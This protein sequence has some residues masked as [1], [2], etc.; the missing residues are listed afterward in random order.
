M[1]LQDLQPLVQAFLDLYIL[2]AGPST[3]VVF[4]GAIAP[5]IRHRSPAR[6]GIPPEYEPILNE[7]DQSEFE[8][9]AG[10]EVSDVS[11]LFLD[12][13]SL[14]RAVV[15]ESAGGLHFR[16]FFRARFAAG[17]FDPA[18]TQV[19]CLPTSGGEPEAIVS[20]CLNRVR[21]FLGSDATLVGTSDNPSFPDFSSEIIDE[22]DP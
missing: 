21:D 3:E 22:G 2:G 1:D 13:C 11:Y 16:F 18:I 10:P 7:L 12:R 14:Q 15:S 6:V 5:G 17:Q 9:G 20:E 4:P 8:A 19:V